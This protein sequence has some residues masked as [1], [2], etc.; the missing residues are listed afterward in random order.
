MAEYRGLRAIAER[1]GWKSASTPIVYCL[2]DG[3]PIYLVKGR[4][5]KI[6]WVTNDDLIYRWELEQCRKTRDSY[7]KG[8]RREQRQRKR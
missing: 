3:F 4:G 5:T 8:H 7:R 1:K 6:N 2:R